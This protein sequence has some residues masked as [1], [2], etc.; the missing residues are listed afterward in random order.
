MAIA[1]FGHF[2]GLLQQAVHFLPANAFTEG[3]PSPT[4]AALKRRVSSLETVTDDLCEENKD[5]QECLEGEAKKRAISVRR[6]FLKF[7]F[8]SRSSPLD[9]ATGA[10]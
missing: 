8:F 6:T 10:F 1:Q 7:A 2:D 5:L 3:S 4:K 9:C